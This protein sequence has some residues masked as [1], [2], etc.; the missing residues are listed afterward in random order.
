MAQKQF[1]AAIEIFKYA[2]TLDPSAA[3]TYQ[4]LGEA[5]LQAKKGELGAQALHKAIELDPVGMMMINEAH[6][7][8]GKKSF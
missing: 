7:K 3:R 5:Y 8:L 2:A 6:E 1:E 4:L